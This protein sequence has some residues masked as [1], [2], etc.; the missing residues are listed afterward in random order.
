[1]TIQIAFSA[2]ILLLVAIGIMLGFIL[3]AAFS[4]KEVDS[5]L[6]KT[7]IFF[8]IPVAIILLLGLGWE[9][10]DK[11]PTIEEKLEFVDSAIILTA[12]FVSFLVIKHLKKN[13]IDEDSNPAVKGSEEGE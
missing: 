8:I 1:M 5:L 7:T 10:T 3:V 12:A 11:Y 6:G 13:K 2:Y 4:G 9:I